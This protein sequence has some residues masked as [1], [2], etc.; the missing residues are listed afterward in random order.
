MREI[1]KNLHP[2]MIFDSLWVLLDGRSDGTDE[3]IQ[4][5]TR[6]ATNDIFIPIWFMQTSIN[7]TYMNHK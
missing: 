1:R 7:S 2:T 5:P 4:I 6:V 3:T